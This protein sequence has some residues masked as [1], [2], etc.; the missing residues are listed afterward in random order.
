MLLN[1]TLYALIRM[2]EL[3][4]KIKNYAKSEV[5]INVCPM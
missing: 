1:G 2:N 5:F 4:I 3:K